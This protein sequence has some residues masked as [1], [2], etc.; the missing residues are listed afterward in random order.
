[1]KKFGTL[2][3]CVCCFVGAVF[4]AEKI[5]IEKGGS[6]PV[7]PGFEVKQYKLTGSKEGLMVEV[8]N[9]TVRISGKEEGQYGLKLLGFGSQ[10]ASYEIQVGQDIVRLIKNLKKYLESIGGIEISRIDNNI[11]ITGEV[12]DYDDLRK[13]QERI[14]LPDFKGLVVNDVSFV[15]SPDNIKRLKSD[16]RAAGFELVDGNEAETT[17][18]LVFSQAKNE[19]TISGT[20][21]SDDEISRLAHVIRRSGN[22][23]RLVDDKVAGV[24]DPSKAKCT[25]NVTV[26]RREFIMDAVIVGYEETNEERFGT[27]NRP[28]IKLTFGSLL[29]L[30]GGHAKNDVF[31]IE[32]DMA[33]TLDFMKENKISRYNVG[34]FMAFKANDPKSA[35]LKIG[36]TLKVKLQSATAEG[37]PTQ[38]FQDIEYGFTLDKK[39]ATLVNAKTVH[40]ELD[41]SQKT[42]IPSE[43][44]YEEGYD[45]KENRYN[46]SLDCE[47]GK[48]VVVSG[49]RNFF[50]DTVPPSGVPVMRNI[51]II[52]WFMSHE[53]DKVSDMKMMMLVSVREKNKND[54]EA[55]KTVLPYND[56]RDLPTQVEVNNKDRVEARKEAAKK[57]HGMWNWLNWFVP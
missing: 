20:V 56:C 47:I 6:R 5:T 12:N 55:Q 11:Y 18:K 19:I 54:A 30:V 37:Q 23:L 33:H 40:I 57:F 31:S 43:H 50:E 14:A 13:I 22:W 1:M 7:D 42:P 26:D 53:G 44:G 16:I 3:M 15:A 27:E 38:N 10:E 9:G 46:P 29:D 17:G 21:F 36:G 32:T 4:G 25:L 39:V 2:M 24:S 52:K 8:N 35:N 49:Y 45:I 34:G 28:D 51:P 41:I 48:T